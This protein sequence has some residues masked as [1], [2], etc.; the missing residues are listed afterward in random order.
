MS[1]SQSKELRNHKREK[2]ETIESQFLE[3]DTSLIVSMKRYHHFA[4]Y[5]KS[6]YSHE[7][8]WYHHQLAQSL[9]Q[10]TQKWSSKDNTSVT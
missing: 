7:R 9:I 2:K 10:E 5:K 1:I 6:I 3:N 4:N 8:N